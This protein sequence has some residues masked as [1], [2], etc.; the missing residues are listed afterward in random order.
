[1]PYQLARS[2]LHQ[3]AIVFIAVLRLLI[4]PGIAALAGGAW[5]WAVRKLNALPI[6]LLPPK[7]ERARVGLVPATGG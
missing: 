5:I 7:A 6:S 2:A 4:V 1:M 3:N